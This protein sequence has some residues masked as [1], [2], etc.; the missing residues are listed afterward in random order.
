MGLDF[1]MGLMCSMSL[2]LKQRCGSEIFLPGG[3][4][5]EQP[6]LQPPRLSGQGKV[7]GELNFLLQT[8]FLKPY[9][10]SLDFQSFCHQRSFD[11]SFRFLILLKNINRH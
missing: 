9:I 1:L 4:S 11:S 2:Y 8:I 3:T 7:L 10:R 5:L 6:I